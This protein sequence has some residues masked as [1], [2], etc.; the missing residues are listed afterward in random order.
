M[1]EL[2]TLNVLVVGSSPA[3]RTETNFKTICLCSLT[4]EQ[5]AFNSKDLVQF[6]AGAQ[7]TKKM[8][9]EIHELDWWGMEMNLNTILIRKEPSDITE[10]ENVLQQNY[11]KFWL[12]YTKLGNICITAFWNPSAP[13][14]RGNE[15]MMRNNYRMFFMK[16]VPVEQL[17]KTEL[18]VTPEHPEGTLIV[19]SSIES[20]VNHI[21]KETIELY[22]KYNS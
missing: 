18:T 2:H 4:D 10:Q 19:F 7:T 9:R 11:Y 14:K 3:E 12:Q 16:D 17:T 6:Q 21:H 13:H 8:R 22:E 15:L 5:G 20:I 1:V